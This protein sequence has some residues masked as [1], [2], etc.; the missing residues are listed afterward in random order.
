[1]KVKEYFEAFKSCNLL[2]P[3]HPERFLLR[4]KSFLGIHFSHL[5]P[6]FR[7]QKKALR[8][9]THSSPRAHTYPLFNKFKILNI[10]NI[11]KYQVSCFVFLHMQKLLPSPLS[12]LFVLNS[13]CHQYLTRQKDNLHLHT[14]KYSFSLRVQGPQI[15]NDIPLS[16]RNSLTLSSYKHKLR[17]YFQSL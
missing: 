14:H 10:F 7:L 16:L 9:I 13:D 12:S 17:D 15:W 8:I 1:M 4:L 11:Y 2:L 5:Q 3:L 6:L